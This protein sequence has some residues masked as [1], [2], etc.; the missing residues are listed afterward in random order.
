MVA[1]N[2]YLFFF[3]VVFFVSCHKDDPVKPTNAPP[4]LSNFNVPDTI[5]T[6]IDQSYIISVVVTDEDGLE[7]IASVNY[8]IVGSQGSST[9]GDF[10]DNGDFETH[11][12][13]IAKDGKYSARLNIDFPTGAYQI[14]AKA[15]DKSE[16]ESDPLEET[17]YAI[18][19]KINH[20][21]T[22]TA[23]QIPDCCCVVLIQL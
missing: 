23:V 2:F 15:I 9:T 3:I 1:K 7:D 14:T 8:E 21:P 12:D 22:V 4:I 11:G 6:K 10:Y 19:G 17:F 16:L 5:F 20:A 13:N 18:E